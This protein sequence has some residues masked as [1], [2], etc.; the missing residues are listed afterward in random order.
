MCG[1]TGIITT[2]SFL[3]GGVDF[4]KDS[5]LTSQ[6]RGV[7]STG[8][9]N[10]IGKQV[11]SY[12]KATNASNF[13]ELNEAKPIIAAAGRADLTV[14]H[15]R[16]AT[17]GSVNDE[18]AHPFEVIREDGSKIIGVHNGTLKEWKYKEGGKDHD[19]DS[20]WAFEM[21]A[22]EGGDAFEYFTGAYALVWWDSR[23]PDSVFMIRNEQRPLHYAVT[24]DGKSMLFASELG[25]LGWV[26]ERNKMKVKQ[27]KESS[28]FYFLKPN[29]LYKFSLNK[30]GEYTTSNP[31]K[32]NPNTGEAPTSTYLQPYRYTSNYSPKPYGMKDILAAIK[33]SLR[34]ARDRKRKVEA[35][36]VETGE[37]IE[38][39]L[40]TIIDAD[41]I[42]ERLH[43]S[44]K[45]YMDGQDSPTSKKVT[46]EV[47][48]IWDQLLFMPQFIYNPVSSS[49]NREEEKKARSM[50][51]YGQVVLFKGI[52]YEEETASILGEF[53]VLH[54]N[55]GSV[56]TYDGEIRFSKARDAAKYVDQTT[57]MV[58]VGFYPGIAADFPSFVL[59]TLTADQKTMV[60]SALEYAERQVGMLN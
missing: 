50:G 17:L 6:V 51:M 41:A 38:A 30:A 22:K 18:N 24:E 52:M 48:T 49:A 21:I 15:V 59:T 9:F 46:A 4:L 40:D 13:L 55:T 34:E 26:M 36:D 27:S 23:E 14:A 1:I 12:K 39:T 8:L 25:M 5:M 2:S 44:I 45:E 19:V 37:E 10:V 53:E 28:G 47:G 35:K 20:A 32:Y 56:L 31:P 29:L 58:V 3:T 54:E 16:H 42:N 11:S 33:E 7:H 60:E 57:P 43:S